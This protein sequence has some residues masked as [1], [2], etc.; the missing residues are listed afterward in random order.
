MRKGVYITRT[1]Y[2][3]EKKGSTLKQN[4]NKVLSNVAKFIS[5]ATKLRSE[6]PANKKRFWNIRGWLYE[7]LVELNVVGT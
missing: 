5:A 6:I 7:G 1:Y 2:Y 4:G 3:D